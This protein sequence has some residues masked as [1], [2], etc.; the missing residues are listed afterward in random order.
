MVPHEKR[1]HG[2]HFYELL[3]SVFLT[4]WQHRMHVEKRDRQGWRVGEKGDV[5]TDQD[6]VKKR[7]QIVDN[8]KIKSKIH[9]VNWHIQTGHAPHILPRAC[10]HYPV[11]VWVWWR[12]C[13]GPEAG[14]QESVNMALTADTYIKISGVNLLTAASFIIHIIFF[15]PLKKKDQYCKRLNAPYWQPVYYNYD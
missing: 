9:A 4:R 10:L 5:I 14:N 13:V 3:R 15:E 1:C 12:W 8:F 7:R 11:W 2:F 6:K